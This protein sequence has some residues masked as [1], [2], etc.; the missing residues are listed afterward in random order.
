[1]K[2]LRGLFG[3]TFNWLIILALVIATI[4][5]VGGQTLASLRGNAQGAMVFQS[6]L[7]TPIPSPPPVPTTAPPIDI[8]KLKITKVEQVDF[9]TYLYSLLSPDGKYDL[10]NKTFQGHQLLQSNDGD[11]SGMTGTWINAYDLWLVNQETK[12]ERLITSA[13]TNWEWSPD[14][15]A[16]SFITPIE[17]QGIVGG[18]YVLDVSEKTPRQIAKADLVLGYTQGVWLSIEEVMYITDGRLWVVRR[19]GSDNRQLNDLRLEQIGANE[20]KELAAYTGNVDEFVVSP[21]GKRIAYTLIIP[22]PETN[23]GFNSELWVSDIDGQNAALLTDDG[24]VREWSP[25]GEMLVYSSRAWPEAERVTARNLVL[26]NLKTNE[27][28]IIYKASTPYSGAGNLA[29]SPDGSALAFREEIPSEAWTYTLWFT[30][31]DGS[32]QKSFKDLEV[33][34]QPSIWMTWEKDRKHLLIVTPQSGGVS[35]VHQIEISV[36]P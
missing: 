18:L 19:D 16:F 23:L 25:N 15:S 20:A 27:Q 8:G 35:T 7:P 32:K 9:G 13:A 24:I 26:A 4:L 12:E 3:T 34:S 36:S 22:N 2:G 6:P 10:T 17:K 31:L 28:H 11:S 30:N 21:D 5:L 29:W 33:I 14:S 1:M